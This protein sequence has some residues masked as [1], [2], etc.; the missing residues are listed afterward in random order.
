M[1]N[2][3]QQKRNCNHLSK[4]ESLIFSVLLK[5]SDKRNCEQTIF[6]LKCI[7]LS[8][9]MGACSG[10]IYKYLAVFLFVSCIALAVYLLICEYQNLAYINLQLE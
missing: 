4:S 2:D 10:S 9:V 7:I 5:H 8:M 6:V 1:V 3:N